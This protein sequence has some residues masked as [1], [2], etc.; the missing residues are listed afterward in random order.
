MRGA[1]SLTDIAVS[2]AGSTIACLAARGVAVC[3]VPIDATRLAPTPALANSL[4]ATSHRPRRALVHNSSSGLAVPPHP[5]IIGVIHHPLQPVAV[6]NH[7]DIRRA[8]ATTTHR[9]KVSLSFYARVALHGEAFFRSRNTRA[10]TQTTSRVATPTL[11]ALN[12]PNDK[13][14]RDRE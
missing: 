8:L 2:D 5:N 14:R 4:R 7:V 1:W 13:P 10:F 6:G 12:N 3:T 9:G 11:L